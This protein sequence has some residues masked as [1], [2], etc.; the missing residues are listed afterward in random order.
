MNILTVLIKPA[1][2]ACNLAC[3]YCFYHS[4][5]HARSKF[6]YGMMSYET[7]ENLIKKSFREAKYVVYFAFQGGE[8]TLAGLEFYRQFLTIVDKYKGKKIVKYSLQT[9]AM[10]LDDE[11]CKFFHDNDFLVGVSLDGFKDLHDFLRV[12]SKGGKSFDRV[13]QSI[14]ILKKHDVKFNILSVVTN[15]MAKHP[16]K[17]FQFYLKNGFDFIQFIPCLDD[18]LPTQNPQNYE[19][20][21]NIYGKFLITIFDLWLSELKRGHYIS[22]RHIDNLMLQLQ[23]KAPELCGADGRCNLQYVIEGDGSVYPCDFYCTDE[24][25]MGN[26]NNDTFEQLSSSIVAEKFIERRN[27]PANCEKCEYNYVCNS[28]CKRHHVVVME[29]GDISV[30]KNRFCT[31]YKEFYAHSIPILKNLLKTFLEKK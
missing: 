18:Y 16:L 15:I 17:V 23:G 7:A 6:F 8:P 22:I 11:W 29:L 2:S 14:E 9:N 12:D 21:A 3:K 4:L 13:M 20:Q 27:F 24:F 10:I 28:G 19:L 1:S 31:A 30:I 26:I 25:C 5:S